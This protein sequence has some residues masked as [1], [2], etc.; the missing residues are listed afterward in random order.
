MSFK[1]LKKIKDVSGRL[2]LLASILVVHFK[3]SQVKY[4]FLL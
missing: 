4:V 3:G 1:V 2:E